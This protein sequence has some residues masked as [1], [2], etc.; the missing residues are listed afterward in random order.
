MNFFFEQLFQKSFICTKQTIDLLVTKD[1]ELKVF[2]LT[3][4]L[5][6]KDKSRAIQILND[7]LLLNESPIKI[8]GLI[9]GHF[10]RMMFAKINKEGDASLANALG[11]RE[12]AITKAK[13]QAMAFT[14]MQLKKIEAL[15]LECDYI[16]KS[17]Q[18]SQENAIYYLVLAIVNI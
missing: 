18:M 16:I 4:A 3:T 10:R 5:G 14:A 15:I 6:Q 17:G 11:C 12:Y 9:S 1:I 8:L 2:D 7:M 13:Q